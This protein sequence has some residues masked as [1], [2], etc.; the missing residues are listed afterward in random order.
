MTSTPDRHD[1]ESPALS[2]LEPAVIHGSR[3]S[4]Q[5]GSPGPRTARPATP[6]YDAG[7]ECGDSDND[8]ENRR[9]TVYDLSS[10]DFAF[11]YKYAKAAHLFFRTTRGWP[12]SLGSFSFNILDIAHRRLCPEHANDL[13]EH[14]NADWASVYHALKAAQGQLEIFTSAVPATEEEIQ[15]QEATIIEVIDVE[16]IGGSGSPH[17]EGLGRHLQ[18][19]TGT[20]EE[21]LMKDYGWI[22]YDP[23]DRAAVQVPYEENGR[24]KTCRWVKYNL[25]GPN[26]MATGT[27]GLMRAVY[28]VDLHANPCPAPNYTE[29]RH[30]RDDA[31]QIFHPDHGSRALVDRALA[32]FGDPRLH[33]EVVRYRFCLAERDDIAQSCRD[34]ARTEL[35]NDEELLACSQFLANTRGASRIGTAIFAEVPPPVTAAQRVSPSPEPRP[36]RPRSETMTRIPP[37]TASQ[38]PPDRPSPPIL[39]HEDG[40]FTYA[41]SPPDNYGARDKIPFCRHC[42]I[43]G[44]DEATCTNTSCYFCASYDHSTFACP[45]PHFCCQDDH[46]WVPLSHSYHG[47]ACPAQ[48]DIDME[49]AGHAACEYCEDLS[50]VETCVAASS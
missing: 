4:S 27:E 2:Y 31:L 12:L 17:S 10:G 36:T 30:F 6:Y 11:V 28:K 22:E 25:Q 37:I 8:K 18:D 3:D 40:Q 21:N 41:L 44:H 26:P 14:D 32:H 19:V 50:A 33:A 23:F 46:C 1:T 15:K 5:A 24:I 16:P 39:P 7:S 45:R 29:P 38:G 43:R 49:D 9:T 35:Q 47:L 34:V 42:Q 13:D 48:V 20:E